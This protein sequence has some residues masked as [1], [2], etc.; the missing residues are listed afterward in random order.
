MWKAHFGTDRHE[1]DR[2]YLSP[3]VFARQWAPDYRSVYSKII[4]IYIYI[5][6]EN[7]IC[8]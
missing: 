8:N 1:S 5:S 3:A 2:L 4:L 6:D 7:P